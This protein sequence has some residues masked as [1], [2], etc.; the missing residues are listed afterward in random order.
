MTWLIK[1]Y[2]LNV[3]CIN[4]LI[5]T[6]IFAAQSFCDLIRKWQQSGLAYSEYNIFCSLNLFTWKY[7]CDF[8]FRRF[9]VS[10]KFHKQTILYKRRKYRLYRMEITNPVIYDIT[11]ERGKWFTLNLIV[12]ASINHIKT[13]PINEFQH[14]SYTHIFGWCM[15]SISKF[16]VKE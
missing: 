14:H 7:F 2:N 1:T 10:A 16:I 5:I 15:H 12:S 11:D 6:S 4:T 8:S 9:F 13:L 3:L